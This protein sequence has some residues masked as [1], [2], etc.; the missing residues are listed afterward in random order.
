MLGVADAMCLDMEVWLHSWYRN[1]AEKLM[2]LFP[3]SVNTKYQ[4]NWL[5]LENNK[6][7]FSER[8]LIIRKIF[9]VLSIISIWACDSRNSNSSTKYMSDEKCCIINIDFREQFDELDTLDA[10]SVINMSDV[11]GDLLRIKIKSKYEIVRAEWIT[12]LYPTIWSGFDDGVIQLVYLFDFE[13]KDVQHPLRIKDKI[14]EFP[15][16]MGRDFDDDVVSFFKRI[17]KIQILNAIENIPKEYVNKGGLMAY[18]HNSWER[19]KKV[20]KKIADTYSPSKLVSVHDEHFD[21]CPYELDLVVTF[22]GDKG[23]FR[24]VFRSEYIIGN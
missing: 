2:E 19:D 1:F 4:T 21:I 12:H 7:T 10:R 5:V 24:K 23:E 3:M 16:S 9:I 17:T 11:Y 8:M 14:I 15:T 6:N 13:Y 18:T 22:K 20:W